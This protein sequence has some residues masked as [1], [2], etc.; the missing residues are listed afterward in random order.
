MTKNIDNMYS[1]DFKILSSCSGWDVGLW[2]VCHPTKIA[3]L[4]PINDKDFVF[5]LID[6]TEDGIVKIGWMSC[7]NG[8]YFEINEEKAVKLLSKDIN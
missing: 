2:I 3:L 1:N 4:K 5:G 8:V 7:I 6:N